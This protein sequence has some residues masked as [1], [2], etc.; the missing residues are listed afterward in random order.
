VA[1]HHH[2]GVY[3]G[4]PPESHALVRYAVLRAHDSDVSG[5]HREVIERR[6]RVLRLDRQHHKVFGAPLNFRRLSNHRDPHRARAARCPHRQTILPDCL[7]VRTAGDQE[8]VMPGLGQ[9][10][11]D[12]AADR[13]RAVDDVAQ[14]PALALG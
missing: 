9:T 13:A 10:A 3:A 11:A 1:E 12:A 7:E 8:N 6:S 14:V 4:E 2:H 5:R